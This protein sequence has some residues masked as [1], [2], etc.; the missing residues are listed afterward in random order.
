MKPVWCTERGLTTAGLCC[1]CS[2]YRQH[3]TRAHF[4]GWTS[5]VEFIYPGVCGCRT[6]DILRET[7]HK[8]YVIAGTRT[9]NHTY[10]TMALEPFC[11]CIC[12]AT[13]LP[14]PLRL[15]MCC[16]CYTHTHTYIHTKPHNT[17]T[18]VVAVF[19]EFT[20][21]RNNTATPP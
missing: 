17:H 21:D 18:H 16:C 2:V 14:Q 3:E 1:C 7:A 5:L 10:H 9:H 12:Q 19:L 13:A 4:R 6:G 11:C 15:L 20:D 8:Q